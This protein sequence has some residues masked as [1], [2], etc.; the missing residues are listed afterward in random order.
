MVPR[1]YT[2]GSGLYGKQRL[3]NPSFF[4]MEL[5]NLMKSR[6]FRISQDMICATNGSSLFQ[7]LV[8]NYSHFARS[9]CYSWYKRIPVTKTYDALESGSEKDFSFSLSEL[10]PGHYRSTR[11]RLTRRRGSVLDL[12]IEIAVN[13]N[14][15]PDEADYYLNNPKKEDLAY[16]SQHVAP[17][18]EISYIDITDGCDAPVIEITLEP[19]EVSLIQLERKYYQS[20]SDQ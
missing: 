19:H 15:T 16:Y 14:M 9:Y 7:L 2:I 20:Q 12:Y 10:P 17:L 5:M 4:A 8:V 11:D 3:R 18:R 1:A 6:T 13:G